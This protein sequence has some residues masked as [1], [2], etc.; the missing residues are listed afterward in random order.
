MGYRRKK[1]D[2]IEKRRYEDF[3]HDN[4]DLLTSIGFPPFIT[5]DYDHFIYYLEH[6]CARLDAP[7]RFDVSRSDEQRMEALK[8]LLER[9]YEAGL[10]HV[11]NNAVHPE[12]DDIARKFGRHW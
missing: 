1:A 10:P 12:A 8:H 11:A 7:M 4:S 3:L 9:Y 2:A 5:D 6:G